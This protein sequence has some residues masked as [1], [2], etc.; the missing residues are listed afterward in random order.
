M[1]DKLVA[2]VN[3]IDTRGFVLKAKNDTD[4]SELENKVPDA[5]GLVEKLDYNA[6][7]TE[8][9]SKIDSVSGSVTNTALT[10]IGNKITDVNSLVNKTD[11]NTK[12]SKAEKKFTVYNHDKYITTTKFNKRNLLF[13]IM[14]SIILLQN[15]V[16]L[17]KKFLMKD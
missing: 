10:T 14:I 1:Y 3:S 17:Q 7:I 8:I 6:K 2:K 4:K 16:S 15:L 12:V 11:Y 13:I 9:E 5:S